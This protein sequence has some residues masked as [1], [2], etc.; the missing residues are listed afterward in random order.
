MALVSRPGQ[1]EVQIRWRSGVITRL[2][3]ERYRPGADSLKTPADAVDRIHDLAGR[4]TYAEI[5]A[6]LNAEGWRTAFGHSF[7]PQHVR[8]IC[9]R[10]GVARGLLHSELI[11]SGEKI[12]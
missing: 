4:H 7:T 3:V 11:S 9:R 8:Y 10:N 2:I 6:Q 12:H 5:A 1:I